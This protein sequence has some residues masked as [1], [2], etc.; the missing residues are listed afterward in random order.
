[1]KESQ[2]PWGKKENIFDWYYSDEND[3]EVM[4]PV[5]SQSGINIVQALNYIYHYMNEGE[6][7][8]A[9]NNLLSLAELIVAN[10]YDLVDKIV[11]DITIEQSMEDFDNQIS[12]I[13][14]GDTPKE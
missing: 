11:E 6:F 5:G 13:L 10:S 1:M 8:L 12:I 4:M 3:R 9:N 2:K 7:E 14:D